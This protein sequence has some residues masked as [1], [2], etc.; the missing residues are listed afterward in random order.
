MNDALI[1]R[2]LE[3][4]SLVPGLESYLLEHKDVQDFES[5]INMFRKECVEL[6]N[7]TSD[8]DLMLKI[9]MEMYDEIQEKSDNGMHFINRTIQVNDS[10][11]LKQFAEDTKGLYKEGWKFKNAANQHYKTITERI[12]YKEV[13]YSGIVDQYIDCD[14]PYIC[15]RIALAYLNAKIY[16]V[17]LVFLQKALSHVFSYPNVYWHNPTA[18][19]GCVDALYE[20]QFLLGRE[21]MD[22][23]DVKIKGGTATIL[24]C[25]YL[26]LSRAI[27]M[28]DSDNQ[29]VNSENIPITKAAKLDYLCNRANLVY[30]YSFDFQSLFGIGVNPDI[31][32]LSD[33]ATA[34][35]LS[36]EY[37]LEIMFQDAFNDAM[38]MYQHGSLI[39]NYSGGYSEIEEA[40]FAELIQR[41][42][43]RADKYAQELYEEYSN[44]DFYISH[45]DLADCIAYLKERLVDETPLSFSEF[46]DRR[47]EA[48]L[49]AWKEVSESMGK[50]SPSDLELLKAQVTTKKQDA[51]IIKTYLEHNGVQYFYHFTDRRNLESIIKNGGLFSWK[52]S[53]DNGVTITCPGGDK[54]SRELDQRFG[55]EDYVRLSFCDDH[56]MSW[57]LKK[58]GSDL[59][60]LKIK[61]EVALFSG[62]LFSDIN[63]AASNHH[64]GGS[65]NDLLF[66]DIRA[67]R[68]HYLRSTDPDFGK[69]QAEVM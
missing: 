26:Y 69:H 13:D 25:L 48:W 55:L 3:Y 62:T 16:D 51:E 28:G 54:W 45:S 20:F 57:R 8:L 23:L 60:L 34:Y 64:H 19:Y 42:Q 33:K 7:M 61:K 6:G 52:Y 17:G 41:G 50:K 44:G 46:L 4:L 22:S 39:P 1:N 31:Q 11:I 32:F 67:T 36:Q 12:A 27:Y 40:T 65:Y 10:E 29:S 35:Y 47:S 63:A 66:V 56:P 68:R 43:I 18:L 58:N 38:K 30:D 24:K 9:V 59:V 2:F 21:G 53:L 5:S 37:G 49:A 15:S 14:H